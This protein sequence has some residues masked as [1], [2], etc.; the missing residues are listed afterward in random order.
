MAPETNTGIEGAL[1]YA[2][3]L[4]LAGAELRELDGIHVAVLPGSDGAWRTEIID[5]EAYRA[6]P[7]RKRGS[8]VTRDVGSF[9]E[10]VQRHKSEATIA[11]ADTA[12]GIRCVLNDHGPSDASDPATNG[13]GDSSSAGW[14]D[15]V[16]TLK[17]QQTRGFA[18]WMLYNEQWLTQQQFAEF[19]EQRLGEIHEPAGADLLEVSQFFQAHTAITVVSARK[20]QNG[21]V[22]M[23]YSE[24]IKESGGV[25]GDTKVPT[26]FTLVLRPYM[27]SEPREKGQP[28]TDQ[29]VT[30]ARLYYRLTQGKVAFMFRLAEEFLLQLDGVNN[31]AIERVR[32]ETGIPV[33][34]VGG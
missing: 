17:R 11:W 9:I 2:A 28:D 33:L 6:N 13:I 7:R 25:T 23:Q 14:G 32:A 31:A 26:E 15:H 22:Q 20:L 16:V 34:L 30:M 21:Q 12:G 29:F 24:E 3:G 8:V 1:D 27:D 5:T 19:L 10:Y 18:A 4:A